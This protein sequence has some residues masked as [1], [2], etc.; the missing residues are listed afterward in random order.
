M[1]SPIELTDLRVDMWGN[2]FNSAGERIRNTEKI[3]DPE[4]ED[5]ND[6]IADIKQA[7]DAI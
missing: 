6:L 3:I 4:F 2:R 7:L 1:V 5:K